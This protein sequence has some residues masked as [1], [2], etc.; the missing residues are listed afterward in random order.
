MS[1][2]SKVSTS[3]FGLVTGIITFLLFA[4]SG[5]TLFIFTGGDGSGI[6]VEVWQA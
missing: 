1:N 3:I 6:K 2:N 5:T 4:L